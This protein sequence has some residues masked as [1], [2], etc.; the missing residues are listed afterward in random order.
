MTFSGFV[1]VLIVLGFWLCMCRS[2]VAY[3]LRKKKKGKQ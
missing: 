1:V 3:N 2:V